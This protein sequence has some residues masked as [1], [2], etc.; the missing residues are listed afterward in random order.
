MSQFSIDLEEEGKSNG[1]INRIVSAVH[2]V[3]AH[4]ADDELLPPAPR[5][6][7]LKENESRKTWY[8]KEQVQGLASAA[9]DPYEREDLHDIILCAGYTG[10]RQGE[11]LK[12]KVRDVDFALTTLHVGG[13][14]DVVTK[15]G[16]YRSIPIHDRI[17]S[18]LR[19]RTEERDP[20]ALVF[21]RDWTDR[22]Q[23][24]R[25]FRKVRRYM[26]IGEDH[27]FHTLRHSYATW[28][29][30]ADVPLLTIKEL[31]GHKSIETTMLYAKVTSKAR[32][33]AMS[34]I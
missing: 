29:A 4:C 28:L 25:A 9:L 24:M 18:I 33:E 1:T 13:R 2:T 3:L 21:G 26:G 14:P 22:D 31:M 12:L 16:N 17:E 32:S 5:F 7:R 19:T 11:L 30:E 20:R 8:S 23:L 15:P 6:R 27:V 10:M 34:R